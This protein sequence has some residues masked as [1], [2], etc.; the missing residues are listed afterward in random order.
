MRL[1]PS[2]ERVKREVAAA[3]AQTAAAHDFFADCVAAL[4]CMQG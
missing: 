4:P 3:G 1:N 2:L